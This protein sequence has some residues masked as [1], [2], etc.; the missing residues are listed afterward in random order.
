[1]VTAKTDR[2]GADTEDVSAGI[3]RSAHDAAGMV[4]S[5]Y[6]RAA[7]KVPDAVS[8]AQGAARDTQK[9]LDGMPNQGLM[10]GASLSLGLGV[11]LF[12]SGANRL[13]VLLSLAPAV[14]MIATLLGREDQTEVSAG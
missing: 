2:N 13:L 11:G 14:A 6:D 4:K 1:M 10:I 12:I 9:A 7:E 8:G 5:T 3:R